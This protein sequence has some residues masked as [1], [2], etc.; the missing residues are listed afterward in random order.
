MGND[1]NRKLE[2]AERRKKEAENGLDKNQAVSRFACCGFT[3]KAEGDVFASV[4]AA[5]HVSALCCGVEAG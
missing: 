4:A 1:K 3:D 5:V 2:K